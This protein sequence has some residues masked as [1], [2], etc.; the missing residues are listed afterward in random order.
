M[1]R[2][3]QE[4]RKEVTVAQRTHLGRIV[5]SLNIYVAYFACS[6]EMQ[7]LLANFGSDISKSIQAKRKRME[8]FAQVA[9]KTSSKKID[10]LW[11][12]QQSER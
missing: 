8:N 1:S 6:G 9:L 4:E 11:Q 2:H 5:F 12:S 7:S 3:L 10:Q